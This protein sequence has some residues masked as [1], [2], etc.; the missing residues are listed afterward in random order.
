MYK[1][2]N[3]N[4]LVKYCSKNWNSFI[5]TLRYSNKIQPKNGVAAISVNNA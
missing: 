5:L 2:F 3:G 1:Q 4:H